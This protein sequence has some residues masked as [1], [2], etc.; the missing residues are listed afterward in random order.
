MANTVPRPEHPRPDFE[1]TEWLSLNG[2]WEFEIDAGDSGE[3]RGL[4]AGRRLAGVIRVP[5][6]PESPLSGVG[7]LD[8][9]EAVWYRR[10]VRV[11]KAWNG[12][13]VL[14]HFG[15]VDYEATV[16]VNGTRVGVHRGGYVQFSFDVTH[17]LRPGA[18][19][20]VVRAVDRIRTRLQPSGK[21]SHRHESYGCMYRRTTGIWQSVWMEAVGETY[22]ERIT[23]TPDLDSGRVLIQADVQGPPAAVRAVVRSGRTVVAQAEAPAT[24]RSTFVALDVPE[25]CPWSPQTP[26]LYELEL[27]IARRGKPLDRVSSYFGF[28]KVHLDGSRFYLNGEVL[29]QRLVLDQGF[30]PKGIYTARSDRALKQDI[31]L[32]QAMG[33]NGARLHQKVFEPRFLYW[34]DRLGY[35][36]WGEFP[37][38]GLDMSDAAAMENLAAE[39]IEVVQRDRNHPAIIGWCP[40]NETAVNQRRESIEHLYRVTRALDPARPIIDTSGYTHVLTDV[41]DNHDYAQNPREFKKREDPLMQGKPFR[42]RPEHDA[43]YCGQPFICSEFGGIWWNPG[44]KDR[45]AWGYGERPRSAAEFLTRLRGLTNALVKNPS[46]SGFCYTQLTD[47]EQEVNGLYTFDRKPKFPADTIAKIFRAKAAIEC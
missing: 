7:H 9:M 8:F 46:M 40:T 35:L 28:R 41:D 34:A 6:C 14:L 13:R 5:F 3:S 39:W 43:P 10:R 18:N 22:L 23:V 19:E 15:A 26:H 47:V 4:S 38:W 27:T 20:I 2:E 25:V 44:Q 16:W 12:R 32:G 17:A 11:P 21:Q 24:W 37:D 42:N 30:Y 1:R 31:E 33:F 29:F 45:E 36:V